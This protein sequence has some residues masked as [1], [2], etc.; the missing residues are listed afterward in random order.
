M[1]G[2]PKDFALLIGKKLADKDKGG[3]EGPP[4]SLGAGDGPPE[5]DEGGGEDQMKL[6]A[7]SDF[8]SGVHSKSPELASSA[9]EDFIKIVTGGGEP[10]GDEGGP[11]EPPEEAA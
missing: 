10:D 5:D 2:P 1:S 4:M 3:G 11:P 7:M 9:L 8:I 6:S